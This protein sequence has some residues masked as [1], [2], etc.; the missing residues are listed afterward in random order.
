M[1]FVQYYKCM[2]P[3]EKNSYSS[4]LNQYFITGFLIIRPLTSQEIIGNTNQYK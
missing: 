2:D 1:K 3:K 4:M